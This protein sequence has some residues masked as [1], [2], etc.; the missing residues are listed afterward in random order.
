LEGPSGSALRTYVYI[1]PMTID[2]FT[3][4]VVTYDLDYEKGV[5]QDAVRV[6][7]KHDIH[8][9]LMHVDDFMEMLNNNLWMGVLTIVCLCLIV[10]LRLRLRLFLT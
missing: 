3:E 4:E 8:L 5:E 7:T 2:A 9:V 10:M 1:N 6:W